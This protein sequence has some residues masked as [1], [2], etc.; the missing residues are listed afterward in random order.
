MVL[1]LVIILFYLMFWVPERWF[2]SI[3]ICFWRVTDCLLGLEL[4][5]RI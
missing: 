5:M 4:F 3:P 2:I 1:R